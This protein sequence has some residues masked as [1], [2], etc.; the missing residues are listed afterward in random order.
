MPGV[1][2]GFGLLVLEEDH[3][4]VTVSASMGMPGGGEHFFVEESVGDGVGSG[5]DLLVLEF[6]GFHG[7]VIAKL[8]KKYF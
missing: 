1:F 5:E 6:V 2:W 7:G 8:C 4:A 3:F